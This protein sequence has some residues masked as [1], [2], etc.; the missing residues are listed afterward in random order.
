[1]LT[2]DDMKSFFYPCVNRIVELIEGQVA[3]IE[4]LRVRPKVRTHLA[5]KNLST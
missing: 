4:R 1:M 5:K 3:Q 2:S